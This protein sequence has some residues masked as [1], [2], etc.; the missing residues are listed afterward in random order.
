MKAAEGAIVDARIPPILPRIPIQSDK[1]VR[2]DWV[3]SKP[4]SSRL[5]WL[6]KNENLDSELQKV[7]Q[8]VLA[9]LDPTVLCTYPD[10]GPL[11]R[12]LAKAMTVD[13]EMLVLTAGSDGAIRST[14]EAFVAEGDT[15]VHTVPTFAMYPVYCQIFGANAIGVEYQRTESGPQLDIER[16]LW[17]VENK[18]P[19]LV[20][21]PNPDS[22][23]GTTIADRDMERLLV[24]TAVTGS[25]LLVDEA[26]YP[27][28]PKS[29]VGLIKYYPNLIVARTFAKAWGLAGLRIGCAV[30]SKETILF[31]HK[32]R[33][34]YEVNTVAVAFLEKMLDH[35]VDVLESVNR[36]NEGKRYFLN[37]M[38]MLGF[39]TLNG[40][41]NFLH[42]SFGSYAPTVF[43]SLESLV[44]FRQDFGDACLAGY[45]RFSS[46][47]TEEFVPIVDRIRKVV[48]DQT[49]KKVSL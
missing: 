44:L 21:L 22:P 48:N 46:T 1:L 39:R 49:N 9:S 40:H 20:C 14:F 18:K 34:M 30:G 3:S 37:E 6:D 7:T 32:I 47:T 42:V 41:G 27:F 43:A 16:L 45:S 24:A 12:K 10:S 4:R 36:L 13:P 38:Q 2:P 31:L 23:T 17:L 5:L 28:Y 11:Y 25:I 35:E 8:R 29:V 19:K 15:V 26:Y 33:P